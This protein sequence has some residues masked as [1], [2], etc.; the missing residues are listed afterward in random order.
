ME[1]S[2]C[3]THPTDL[4]KAQLYMK[5]IKKKHQ[6]LDERWKK[7]EISKRQVQNTI[8][9]EYQLELEIQKRYLKNKN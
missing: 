4:L 9:D 7:W 5:G 8:W 3:G 2:E 6:E 1:I